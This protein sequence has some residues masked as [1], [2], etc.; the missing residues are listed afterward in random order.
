MVLPDVVLGPNLQ[1]GDICILVDHMQVVE[2]RNAEERFIGDCSTNT[3]GAG[4]C[5]ANKQ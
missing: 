5:P 1:S 3:H 4:L 2:R